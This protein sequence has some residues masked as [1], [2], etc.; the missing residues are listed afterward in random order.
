MPRKVKVTEVPINENASYDD[1]VNSVTTDVEETPVVESTPTIET[2]APIEETVPLKTVP[3][4]KETAKGTCEGCGKTMT[5]KNLRYAHKS[6]C[7]ANKKLDEQL[8]SETVETVEESSPPPPS[9][10]KRTKTTVNDVKVEPEPKPVIPT[11][12]VV[13][14]AKSKPKA[15]PKT[16]QFVLD[17]EF[18]EQPQEEEKPKPKPKAKRTPKEPVQIKQ[19]SVEENYIEPRKSRLL[20]KIELYD[21]LASQALQ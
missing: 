18:D 2:T 19:Q 20:K 12:P 17:V 6:V 15:K 9:K 16:E 7:P 4:K 14:K 3:E 5:L 13:M 1:V 8:P 10:L 11:E 21:K